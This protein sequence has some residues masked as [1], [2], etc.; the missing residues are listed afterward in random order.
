MSNNYKSAVFMITAKTN[1]HVGSGSSSYGVIDNLVQRDVLTNMPIINSSSLKGSLRAFCEYKFNSY[2]HIPLGENDLSSE[3]INMI[4]GSKYFDEDSNE[5]TQVVKGKNQHNAGQFRFFD[6][7]LCAFPIREKDGDKAYT[8]SYN[9]TIEKEIKEA[10]NLFKLELDLDKFIKDY[11]INEDLKSNLS[12]YELPIIAR[13]QLDNGESKNLWYE[14]VIPRETRF[15]FVVLYPEQQGEAFNKFKDSIKN[16]LVQI[17][18]NAS[19][20]YGYCNIEELKNE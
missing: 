15:Y 7:R 17:G 13:N 1:M 20:G 9:S 11:R 14:Q 4:F 5:K 12:D 16:D 6:A 18:A 8:L 2:K 10:I 19:I 3:D